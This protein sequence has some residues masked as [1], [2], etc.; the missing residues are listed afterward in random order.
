LV[1]FVLIGTVGVSFIAEFLLGR[2]ANPS[3]DERYDH[4]VRRS[5][6]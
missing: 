5:R 3:N 2:Y 6:M 1:I 4:D